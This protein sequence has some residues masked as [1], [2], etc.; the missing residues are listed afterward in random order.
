MLSQSSRNIW[1]C[2]GTFRPPPPGGKRHNSLYIAVTS[3]RNNYDWLIGS[4]VELVVSLVVKQNVVQD[5]MK[6]CN[7]L[8]VYC[9]YVVCRK[10]VAV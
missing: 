9:S 3:F 10:C 7:R 2:S 4:P 5:K 6:S 8:F 1:R